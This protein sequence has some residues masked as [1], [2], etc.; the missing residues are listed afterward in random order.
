MLLLALVGAAAAVSSG[1]AAS[2]ATQ[3]TPA[4]V[5]AVLQPE[6]TFVPDAIRAAAVAAADGVSA[7]EAVARTLTGLQ[8]LDC[9]Y[10][11]GV[12]GRTTAKELEL[13]NATEAML[14]VCQL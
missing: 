12:D 6:L 8:K 7:W 3:M 11:A 2:T 1:Y 9:G 10:D 13:L 4:E 5:T 14:E